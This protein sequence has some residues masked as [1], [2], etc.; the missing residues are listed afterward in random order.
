[1]WWKLGILFL[2]TAAMIFCIIPVRTHAVLF[3]PAKPPEPA[4]WT[5]SG[6]IANMYLTP[7][8][9]WMMCMLLARWQPTSRSGSSVAAS[10]R[11]P[12]IVCYYPTSAIRFTLGRYGVSRSTSKR[13]VYRGSC[14]KLPLIRPNS[15]PTLTARWR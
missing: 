11:S 13:S 9:V 12:T 6:M 4:K 8:T 1:M 14:P 3:D 7:G 5:L 15:R 2:I 10:R